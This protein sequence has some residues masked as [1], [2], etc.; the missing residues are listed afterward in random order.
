MNRLK[1]PDSFEVI[2]VDD[3][4]QPPI[5]GQRIVEIPKPEFNFIYGY[6]P[7]Y[8]K[9][10]K[11]LAVNHGVDIAK[12]EYIQIFSIDHMIT[13]E[14]IDFIAD[15][16]IDDRMRI[17]PLFKYGTLDE[18]GELH[19]IG[20]K[21]LVG[22]MGSVAMRKEN[23]VELG[24]Y[25]KKLVNVYPTGDDLEFDIRYVRKFGRDS[26]IY[27][28]TIYGFP[29]EEDTDIYPTSMEEKLDTKREDIFYTDDYKKWK[30]EQSTEYKK[31]YEE[32]KKRNNDSPIASR[33]ELIGRGIK[34]DINYRVVRNED[35]QGMKNV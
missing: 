24:G 11:A 9:W 33:I 19:I 14:F 29:K 4:S 23:F 7:D 16:D 3:G 26:V 13:M 34:R 31:E 1:L 18:N 21:L 32:A 35:T 17:S 30:G 22:S 5:F 28:P 12:G 6:R 25:D 8:R 20:K 2:M 15:L 10:T 27:G